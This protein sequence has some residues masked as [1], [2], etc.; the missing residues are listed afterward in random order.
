MEPLS[1]HLQRLNVVSKLV[2]GQEQY[3]PEKFPAQPN[4]EDGPIL[5][6]YKLIPT[7]YYFTRR[8]FIKRQ[9]HKDEI[10]VDMYGD[11]I[12][13]PYA[14]ERLRNEA[15]SLKF[16]AQNTTIPVPKFIDLYEESGLLHLKTSLVQEDAIALEDVNP[17]QLPTAIAKV[18]EQMQLAI[19]PQLRNLCR[20][21]IGSVD[22][23][24]PVFPPPR[25]W[26][27]HRV[28]AWPRMERGTDEYVFCHNDLG[29]HNI[30]VD[31]VFMIVCIIDW[32]FAGFFPSEFELPLW[33]EHDPCGQCSV[34]ASAVEREMAFFKGTM[35]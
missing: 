1:Q 3:I 32:E 21:Y 27:Q 16:I 26:S 13:I 25:L 5:V 20:N 10:G 28:Q 31:S 22:V 35:A 4:D 34:K 18:E 29:P 11:P 30:F 9:N 8:T 14:R 6:S 19:L 23:S 33:R 17:S 12:T 15:A 2:R 24:L 7:T